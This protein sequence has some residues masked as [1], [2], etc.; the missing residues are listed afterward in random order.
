[1]T[2]LRLQKWISILGIAS[3][4]EAESWIEQGRFTVNG[5]KVQLGV[6]VD[7]NADEVR[8]DGE[9]IGGE[10]PKKVYY[11]LCKPDAVITTR[12]DPEGRETIFTLPS[13]AKL[14][15]GLFAVG[16]LD[17]HT[18]GLLILSNDGEMV[19][20]LMHPKWK[21]PR[22]YY[23]YV[24]ERLSPTKEARMR[25]GIALDDGPALPVAL[26][27]LERKKSKGAWYRIVVNEGRNR[28]VRRLFEASNA[29]VIRLIRFGFG[30][31]RLN[32]DLAPGQVRPLLRAEILHLLE[33][34]ELLERGD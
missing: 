25:N 16:R 19:H 9:I 29:E 12:S 24:Q 32:D 10:A 18:E 1:M 27:Y 6:K 20:R 26:E 3:R 2:P 11:A 7:P 34:T 15:K 8:L 14:E 13:V 5:K 33:A 31:V 23:V 22:H 21:L 17:F 28:L 4:R 30:E